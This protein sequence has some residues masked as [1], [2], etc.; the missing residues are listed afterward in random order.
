MIMSTN[1]QWRTFQP[2]TIG[3]DT[4]V[5]DFKTMIPNAHSPVGGNSSEGYMYKTYRTSTNGSSNSQKVFPNTHSF[6]T[7]NSSGG[8]YSN[9]NYLAG[10][11]GGNSGTSRNGRF[12]IGTYTANENNQAGVS[13]FNGEASHSQSSS[14]T[15]GDSALGGQGL[16][17]T[18]IIEKLLHSYGFIQCCERQARLFFHFSQFN[19]NIEH[20][21]IG[22]PVEFEMTYDRRTGKPIASAVTKIAPEVVLSEERVT[23][24]VT[25]ELRSEGTGGDLQGRISY[26]NRGECFFLPYGK[27]DVEGGGVNLLAGDRVSFQIATNQ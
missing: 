23:G 27:D 20:L 8:Q 12:P 24:T 2:P 7:K 3:S 4:A 21:K 14:N 25:T 13:T 17:E 1:P 22:D 16:R 11:T 19:G 5:I 26:E 10:S 6:T 15:Y 18:G 9:I